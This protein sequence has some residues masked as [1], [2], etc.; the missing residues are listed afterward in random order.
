MRRESAF[1]LVE[2]MMAA[3]ILGIA[4]IYLTATFTTTHKTSVTVEQV[5][6]AQQNLRVVS[7]L[8][9]RDLRLAGYLVPRHAAVCGVDTTT[10]PDTLIVSNTDVL[11]LVNELETLN[12]EAMSGELGA[13]V[14]GVGVGTTIGGS[15]QTLLLQQS[16]LDV[17]AD[18]AD[19]AVGGGIIVVNRGDANGRSACGV[20]TAFSPGSPGFP[21]GATL[22]VDFLSG[23]I[24]PMSPPIDVVAVPAHAYQITPANAGTGAPAQLRRNG[25][26]IAN[27]VE[28]LQLGLYFDTDD[29]RIIDPGEFRGDNGEMVGDGVAVPYDAATSDVRTLR[30]VQINLVTATKDDDPNQNAREMT[31]QLTGNRTAASLPATDRKRR[32]VYTAMVRLRNV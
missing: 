23:S 2:L 7:E 3:A 11:R 8:M 28:D 19:F 1:S 10:A 5:S 13:R 18:G 16:W 6:E 32:R 15:N 22:T 4:M 20:I 30:Q 21:N 17:Q 25:V 12:P 27:D 9:E 14:N 29:D 24:G 26:L 31:Q